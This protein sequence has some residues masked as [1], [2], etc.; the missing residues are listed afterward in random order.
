MCSEI[1]RLWLDSHRTL[2]HGDEDDM[3]EVLPDDLTTSLDPS[4]LARYR[5]LV[6][7]E[8]SLTPDEA[9]ELQ[10]FRLRTQLTPGDGQ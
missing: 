1:C 9:A 4:T 5:W 3:A 7:H 10:H 8:D 6:T 2:T